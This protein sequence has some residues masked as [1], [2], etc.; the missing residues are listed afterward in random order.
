L[1]QA[2]PFLGFDNP[3]ILPSEGYISLYTLAEYFV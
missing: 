2:L 3:G 1:I